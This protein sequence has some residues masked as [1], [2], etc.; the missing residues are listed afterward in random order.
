MTWILFLI[1]FPLL[2]AVL[3]LLFKSAAIQKWIVIVSSGLICAGAIGLA[4][5][6]TQGEAQYFRIASDVGSKLIVAGDIILALLFL[7]VCRRLPLKQYWIPLLVIVQYGA[8]VWYDLS[9]RVPDAAYCLFIDNLSVIMALVIGIIGSLITVYTI[10]Y[11]KKYHEE[12][13]EVPDRRG[14]FLAAIFLFFFAMYG[15]IFSNSITWI[16]FFWE[17]TTLCSFI[18]IGY[19]QSNEAIHNAFRALWMLL[20]GGLAFSAA[21]LYVSNRVGTVELHRL[22]MMDKP[23]VLVPILLIC[24][25]GLNKAAQFPFA[26]WL[27]GAMVAPTPSSA[28]LH[29]STMVK[30]GVYIVLRCSPVLENTAAGAMVAFIGG[31]G[32]LA[33]S[34][35]AVSQR[36]GKS[37]LA[38]ST[39]ANLGLIILC[40]GVGSHW[41]LWA[42]VLLIIFH[43]LA[44]ALMFLCVGSVEQQTGSRDIEDMHG[45]IS[46]MPLLTLI[47]LVG[48]MGMFLAPFGMLISKWAVLEALAKENPI[49]PAIVIFGGSIMLFFWAKWMGKLVAVTGSKRIQGEGLGIE[50]VALSGLGALTILICALYPIVGQ[51]LIEPLYGYDPMLSRRAVLMVGIMLGFMLLLPLGFL[52]HWKNLVHVEPYLSGANV[53]DPHQFMGFRGVARD[54]SFRNYYIDKYFSEAR[55][56]NGT[57]AASIVLIV[58]MFFMETL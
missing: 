42:A 14:H 40:A 31:V 28:L 51:Y 6:C 16:Y 7:Y 58:L 19:S 3:L 10:G 22:L 34:A 52:I 25:A 11:M 24:F 50:W 26:K 5:T 13:P 12:H 17:I 29:S 57:T 47:M 44:K 49:F 23:L 18:M 2:P 1:L 37:A 41:A 46:R 53:S 43:A 27:L 45:L 32:F 35:L 39:I 36:D 56:F 9:G 15:I 30:A 33:G 8:V 38:Y 54:W 4:V 21:I 48:I 55:L 20:L